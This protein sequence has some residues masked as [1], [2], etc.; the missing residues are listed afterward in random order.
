KEAYEA[1]CKKKNATKKFKDVLE[2]PSSP[3]VSTATP[4]V[5]NQ[6]LSVQQGVFLL[7]GDITTPWADNLNALGWSNAPTISRT[8]VLDLD[9][10]DAFKRLHR[11]NTT[12]RSLFPGLDGYGR[13]MLGRAKQLLDEPLTWS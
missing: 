9:P 10:N 8:F 7:H 12:A 11:M 3:F 2:N 4:M 1:L 6:R 13:F 5:L